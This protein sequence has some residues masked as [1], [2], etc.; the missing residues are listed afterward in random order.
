MTISLPKGALYL[1]HKL[2]QKGEAYVVGGCV[3]DALRGVVPHDWDLCTSETPQQMLELFQDERVLKTGLKHGT[4]TVLLP[5]GA[6]EVTTYRV[7][8]AYSDGRHP[9]RVTFT[10]CITEDLARRD[11]TINAMAYHPHRGLLDPFGGAQ[12]LQ[13]RQIRAVGDADKRFEEDSLRILRGLRFAS[14]LRF[15]I[16]PDCSASVHRNKELLNRVSK[17]RIQVELSKML[18]GDGVKEILLAYP[19][20]LTQIIPSIEPMIGFEQRSAYHCF[21]VWEHTAHAVACA[22]KD[23]IVRWTML[24]H[25]MGKPACFSEAEGVGHFYGHPAKSAAMAHDALRDL[26]MDHDTIRKVVQLVEL[27]DLP[28]PQTERDVKRLLNRLGESQFYR[29]IEVRRADI[30][31]QTSSYRQERIAQADRALSRMQKVIEEGQC[32]SVGDLAV[33]G[34]DI[35]A[36]GIPAG[37]E[38]GNMLHYLLEL[39]MDQAISNDRQCLL[40]EVQRKMR[41]IKR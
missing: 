34:R 31:A 7:D 4:V 33:N 8:G 39:V 1:I 24:F 17:E 23:P 37:P 20:V 14:T 6:Y 19:D 30:L 2:E 40:E 5:D 12:D 26:R 10:G 3:R 36:A 32:F 27:H 16:S 11:F 38:V 22:A 15:T 18:L 29:L 28:L 25:D 35:L 13:D 9:D 21:D 41:R